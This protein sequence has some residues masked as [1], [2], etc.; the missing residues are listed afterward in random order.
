MDTSQQAEKNQNAGDGQ[1]GNNENKGWILAIFGI[2]EVASLVLWCKSEDFSPKYSYVVRWLAVCGF[3]AGGAFIAHKQIKTGNVKLKVLVWIFWLILCTVAFFVKSGPETVPVVHFR[4]FV[5]S[6]GSKKISL[7][8]DFLIVRDFVNAHDIPGWLF[9]PM[10]PGQTNITMHFTVQNDS[11]AFAENIVNWLLLPTNWQCSLDAGWGEVEP[12]T[13]PWM[14]S[15]VAGVSVT[16][17][18]KEW[19]YNFPDAVLS[20]NGFAL[21]DVHIANSKFGPTIGAIALMT[22]AKD[23]PT[24]EVEFGI[25]AMPTSIFSSND[26]EVPFVST[27]PLK[28]LSAAEL[29][30]LQQ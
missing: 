3:I 21:P 11:S 4:F 6:N 13:V 7:T 12:I 20:G 15:I 25:V 10:E 26:F 24:S 8:N 23:S 19:G 16:N 17:E 14:K 1:T 22:R 9:I 28:A 30:K 18:D 2:I 29:E 5:T 27:L